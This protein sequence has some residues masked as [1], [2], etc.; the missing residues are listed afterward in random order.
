MRI[1][2]VERLI[3]LA[4]ALVVLSTGAGASDFGTLFTTP[5]ERARLDRLRRG[6]AAPDSASSVT[7]GRAGITGYVKRS[8]GRNTV[9]IDGIAVTLANPR[10]APLLE[11]KSVR[12]YGDHDDGSLKIER[13]PPK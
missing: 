9:W 13:R 5:Q 1:A 7:P 6:E 2:P 10:A 11:P 12:G 4:L 8:D 3:A